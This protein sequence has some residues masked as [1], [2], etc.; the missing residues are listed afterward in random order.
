MGRD[1]GITETCPH[2]RMGDALVSH[3]F[4]RWDAN[5]IGRNAANNAWL[6]NE[7][8]EQTPTERPAFMF[9]HPLSWSYYPSD[10]VAV[11]EALGEGYAVVSPGVLFEYVGAALGE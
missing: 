1:E 8:R 7:I 10:L 11:S 6:V 9:V 2:Y 4:T 5:N 3:V